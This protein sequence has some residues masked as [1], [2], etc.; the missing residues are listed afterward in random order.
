[1]VYIFKYLIFCTLLV[2][3][4]FLFAAF[5]PRYESQRKKLIRYCVFFYVIFVLLALAQNT[6]RQP[7]VPL[8]NITITYKGYE[9]EEVA[10][11]SSENLEP[12]SI[13]WDI[14][15]EARVG[16]LFDL[17]LKVT[18]NTGDDIDY[19]DLKFSENPLGEYFSISKV[20]PNV[21]IHQEVVGLGGL[22]KGVS[23]EFLFE[24]V[25][26]EKGN[27]TGKIVPLIEEQTILTDEGELSFEL[28]ITVGS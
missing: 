8:E 7:L 20:T 2:F 27:Y 24:L 23:K 1:M 22:I 12:V 17:K 26:K 28:E 14:D 11:K 21:N 6:S 13:A 16:E 19:L 3:M 4:M 18:N 5:L 25:P 15:S 10:E 9:D